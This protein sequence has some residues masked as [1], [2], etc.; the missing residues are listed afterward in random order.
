MRYNS[1]E[2]NLIDKLEP[3]ILDVTPGVTVRA[4]H[5]GRLVC[6]IG[7]GQTYPIY[8]LA[9]LTKV[10]F[11]QQ[12]MMK[13][14]DQNLWKLD[15]KVKSILPDF[16][17]PEMTIVE[18]LTHT[19]GLEWWVPYFKSIPPDLHWIEK[20]NWLYQQI[21]SSELKKS[22]QAI[23]SDLGFMVL[24]F[25]LEK[26]YN[27]NLHE[28][29]LDLKNEFYTTTSFAFN[30]ENKLHLPSSIYAPT[31]E[32]AFRK[33]V[34]RGE[35]HDENTWALGGISTHAGLF[36][37]IDDL[38][39]FGLNLRSQMHGIAR[40]HI[41]QRTA[42]LFSQRAIKKEVGDWALG[43]MMPS[44]VTPSC[45]L[46]F[47]PL[48]I[49]HTGFTGTSFWYDPEIDLLVLVL[50]NRVNYGREN[51]AFISLRPQ[52]HTWIYEAI[53]RNYNISTP[54]SKESHD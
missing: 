38:A 5:Q 40:Y 42:Q 41:K 43:Y 1:L 54:T 31:E 26:L 14:F 32:C 21:N 30:L 4:Y 16:N 3:A 2:K 22:H 24:G 13:A 46:Y 45:G 23:Y 25:V 7:V 47:S 52:I 35:V 34:L 36:G 15:S 18:L 17:F 44:S 53:K 51:K 6:D 49:G 27:K 48:S 39:A 28:I 29:W 10:I 50:S 33:K 9:S 20:R 37:S 11:T 12:A 8:D 19:S